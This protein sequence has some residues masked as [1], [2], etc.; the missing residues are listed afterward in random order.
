MP[1]KFDINRT[2][3]RNHQLDRVQNPFPPRLKHNLEVAYTELPALISKCNT[4]MTTGTINWKLYRLYF[5][6]QGNANPSN[7]RFVRSVFL[8]LPQWALTKTLTFFYAEGYEVGADLDPGFRMA[9][10]CLT[11]GQNS[12]IAHE[13]SGVRIGFSQLASFFQPRDLAGFVLHELVHKLGKSMGRDIIDHNIAAGGPAYGRDPCRT[14][15]TENA[16]SAIT[17]ADN[18]RCYMKEANDLGFLGQV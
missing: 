14:L 17:N 3:V 7:V 12:R 9:A 11:L 2:F 5:D 16:A 15:A 13:G 6:P 18:Y 10:Y 4:F 1:Y 8:T